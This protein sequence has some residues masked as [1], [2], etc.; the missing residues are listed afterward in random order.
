MRVLIAE[1]DPVIGFG[2]ES[3]LRSLGHDVVARVS[4]GGAAVEAT[5]RL[6]PDAI[7][8]DVV[9]PGLDGLAAARE[10]TRY[11]RLPILAIT[12]HDR[13]ELV[14]EAISA[15]IAAYL[16]KPVDA[17]QI[18]RALR[19]AASRH[20]EFEAMRAEVDRL[21]DALES[22]K[23]VERAKGILMDRGLSEQEAFL[24]IQRRARDT[25]CTMDRVAR[26]IIAAADLLA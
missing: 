12:A 14:D 9:M 3:K 17:R 2:L 25:N 7:V 10:I 26:Q 1:D 21:A 4:D 20:A 23:V 13:P 22:R 24:R 15:G 19:L 11:V 16:V 8:M 5:R 18:D 6:R